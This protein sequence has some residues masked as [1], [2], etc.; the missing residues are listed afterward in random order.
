[1]QLRGKDRLFNCICCVACCSISRSC[2]RSLSTTFDCTEW[3]AQKSCYR[4]FWEIKMETLFLYTLHNGEY[5]FTFLIYIS[6]TMTYYWIFSSF[7]LSLSNQDSLL[8]R[9]INTSSKQI[10]IMVAVGRKDMEI[11]PLV[12]YLK[13]K[14]AAGKFIFTVP[15]LPNVCRCYYCSR[16]YF[17]HIP[18]QWCLW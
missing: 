16:R 9:L 15:S 11:R 1:M 4:N 17:V 5:Y 18:S 3:L 6:I 14:D 10:A 12:R 2:S 13:E 7:R 8:D